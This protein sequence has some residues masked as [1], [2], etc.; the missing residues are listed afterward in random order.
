MTSRVSG[1]LI[2][3]NARILRQLHEALH[4]AFR[5]DSHGAAHHAACSEFRERYDGLVFPGG[6]AR[7]LERLERFET[8]EVEGAVCFLEAQ[9]C[10]FRSGYIE[11]RLL[12]R[13]KHYALTGRQ[14]KRLRRLVL[15]SLDGGGRRAFRGYSRL[16]GRLKTDGLHAE[17][18]KRARYTDAEVARRA[19]AVLHVW[20]SQLAAVRRG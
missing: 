6:L 2:S 19:E 11:Q 14:E 8:S 20:R 3:E 7:F 17:V 10:F 18:E 12:Q 16:A 5:D 1:R 4:Q 15:R 13:L 9:P